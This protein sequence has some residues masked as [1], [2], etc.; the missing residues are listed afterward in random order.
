MWRNFFIQA[1]HKFK[2]LVRLLSYARVKIGFNATN[3]C[4]LVTEQNI[5]TL[6][7]KE[8]IRNGFNL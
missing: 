2:V 8:K 7:M 1:L 4:D 6:G 5:L 3:V